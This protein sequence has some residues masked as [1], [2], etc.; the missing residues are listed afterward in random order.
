MT[1]LL[2]RDRLKLAIAST[3]LAVA[4]ALVLGAVGWAA[5]LQ[6]A[7]LSGAT[8]AD[9]FTPIPETPQQLDV[10]TT[11]R[12]DLP[13]PRPVEPATRE[14]VRIA[15]TGALA[16]LSIGLSTGDP[17]DLPTD[18]SGPAL[19]QVTA[20]VLATTDATEQL[21]LAHDLQ[22][23][24]Y[25]DDGSILVLHDHG[26]VL[27]RGVPGAGHVGAAERWDVVLLLRD[28]R[29]RVEHLVRQPT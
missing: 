23:G 6:R 7:V 11:W 16:R 10:A 27:R 15:W 26:L 29:W 4:A 1:R 3:A 19:D 17:A 18:F 2:D 9:V 14:A 13:T 24:F 20:S 25:S 21:P 12:P 28:G 8:P 5:G 22:V